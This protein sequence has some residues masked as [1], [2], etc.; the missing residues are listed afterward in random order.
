MIAEKQYSISELSKEF[1]VTTRTIRFYEDKGMIKPL[2]EG[3]KRIYSPADRT[4][5]RL[6]LRGKRIGLSLEESFEIIQLY[7]EDPDSTKQLKKV[8]QAIE[9][10]KNSIRE[11]KAAINAI[12][13]EINEIETKCTK[14]L[15][16]L[17]AEETP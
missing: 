12:E 4:R 15:K 17:E 11:K 14:A 5:L 7:H 1:E 10:Q 3:Q 8:L 6:I 13:K 9:K 16:S 2:R